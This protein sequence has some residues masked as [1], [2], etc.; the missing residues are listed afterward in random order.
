MKLPEPG[1]LLIAFIVYAAIFIPLEGLV[2]HRKRKLLRCGFGTDLLHSFVNGLL[3][4]AILAVVV[5][6]TI[7]CLGFLIHPRLQAWVV[8]QPWWL[9]LIE[10]LIVQE[11]GGYWG[12]RP[13]IGCRSC[14]AS[15]RCI[16]RRKTGT[17]WRLLICT[18]LIRP[19]S[20]PAPSS[21]LPARFFVSDLRVL[22][23]A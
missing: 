21:R 8:A 6:P 5:V 12:H 14:G 22:H 23:R 11:I 16:M 2:P 7:Y 19:L 13:L 20:E 18:L 4:K 9:Q 17:G 10:A 3:R 1:R 15:M